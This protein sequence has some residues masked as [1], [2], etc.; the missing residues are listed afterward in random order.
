MG[1]EIYFLEKNVIA[2][3][4]CQPHIMPAGINLQAPVGFV[5]LSALR[6]DFINVIF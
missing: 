5:L 2:A 4:A 3:G 1:Y 6:T